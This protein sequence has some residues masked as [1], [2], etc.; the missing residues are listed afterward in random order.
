[1]FA[2]LAAVLFIVPALT[3]KHSGPSGATKATMTLDALN[4]VGEG[5]KRYLGTH[6]RYT[7]H[8]A[9]LI[10]LEPT[11][12]ADLTTVRIQLDVSSDGKTFL[13]QA[14]SDVLSLVRSR[15]ATKVLASS[16]TVLKSGKGVDCPKSA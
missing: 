12:A 2:L 4:R 6:A 14:S 9:D 13:A 7:A 5:E 15:D 10:S 16:C 11:L 8:V 1:M 3:K